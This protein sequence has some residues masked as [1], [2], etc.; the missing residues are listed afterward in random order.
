[1]STF[2]REM[3]NSTARTASLLLSQHVTRI[4]IHIEQ[5]RATLLDDFIPQQDSSSLIPSLDFLQTFPWLETIN[6]DD[7]ED[8]RSNSLS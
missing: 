7:L 4:D 1:M 3:D 8:S 6:M 2:L 5:M